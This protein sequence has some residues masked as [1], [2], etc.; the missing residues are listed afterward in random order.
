M[1]WWGV[2]NY[3]PGL[4]GAD[5]LATSYALVKRFGKSQRTSRSI[6]LSADA[7]GD[8]DSWTR[9]AR[10][11]TSRRSPMSLKSLSERQGK[12]CLW[13]EISGGY[14]MF[15]RIPCLLVEKRSMKLSMHRRT[16][17]ARRYEPTI[18]TVNDFE[19][20]DCSKLIERFA[21]VVE[22]C[23]R[24]QDRRRKI[25]EGTIDEQ[26]QQVIDI[27]LERKELFWTQ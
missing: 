16:W 22:K 4:C 12:Q 14:E 15:S 7:D 5:T 27:M 17:S 26:V 2:F 19:E 20:V 6:W 10:R 11:L 9:I 1:E 21:D 3:R 18:W 24:H 23:L 8:T 13:K 25:L